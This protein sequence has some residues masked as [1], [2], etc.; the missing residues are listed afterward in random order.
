MPIHGS[1][2]L[3]IGEWLV[4]HVWAHRPWRIRG[5]NAPR[6]RTMMH[7]FDN[8]P[9]EPVSVP[10]LFSGKAF[11]DGLLSLEIDRLRG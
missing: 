10:K 1:F 3:D 4:P 2:L 8:R 6:T 5:G 11:G 9:G 7:Q